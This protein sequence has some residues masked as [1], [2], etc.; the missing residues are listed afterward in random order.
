MPQTPKSAQVVRTHVSLFMSFLPNTCQCVLVSFFLILSSSLCFIICPFSSFSFL[1][2]SWSDCNTKLHILMDWPWDKVINIL[3][4]HPRDCFWV[5]FEIRGVTVESDWLWKIENVWNYIKY[6]R[7]YDFMWIG[8]K[9]A[10]PIK[11]SKCYP[12]RKVKPF[13]RD[14][15]TLT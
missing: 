3:K 5:P 7:G 9:G 11:F 8:I 15:L 14:L 6:F 4:K 2:S 13:P 10:S 1:I 12:P